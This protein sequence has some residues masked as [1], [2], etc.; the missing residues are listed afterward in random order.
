MRLH[1]PLTL[2]LRHLTPSRTIDGCAALPVLA[3]PLGPAR[4]GGA[5]RPAAGDFRRRSD[6]GGQPLRRIGRAARPR[7]AHRRPGHGR[8]RR[9]RPPLH[10]R[11]PA[12]R[13][14]RP[15]GRPLR[16]RH[17][18][19]GPAGRHAAAPADPRNWPRSTATRSPTCGG[20]R[21]PATAA[22]WSIEMADAFERA[23]AALL[24]PRS[25]PGSST[26]PASAA[27]C[28][29]RSI[30]APSGPASKRATSPGPTS[31]STAGT[32]GRLDMVAYGSDYLLATAGCAP[33]AFAARDR[34]WRRRRADR[35]RAERRA[36]GARRAA[37]P[38]ADRRRPA[39]RAAM[40]AAPAASCGCASPVPGVRA[41]PRQRP[42]ALS[43]ARRPARLAARF[44]RRPR[45]GEPAP[46]AVTAS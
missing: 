40:A 11:H 19:R 39:R 26:S 24:R 16:P 18:R 12:D 45:P 3:G 25:S 14:R 2:A 36:A 43:R 4:P 10:R 13:G 17:R 41:A 38:H 33:E 44:D 31:A 42:G 20:R 46:P 21:R 6:A 5:R 32:S 8:R 7:A 22:C 1:H 9:A 29:P 15:A 37:L 30:A 34:A 28:T 23:G 35:L 27:W